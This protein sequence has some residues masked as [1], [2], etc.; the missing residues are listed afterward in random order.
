MVTVNYLVQIEPKNGFETEKV[1]KDGYRQCGYLPQPL[2]SSR[3]TQRETPK[4]KIQNMFILKREHVVLGTL[5]VGIHVKRHADNCSNSENTTRDVGGWGR[6]PHCRYPFLTFS[7][8]N[9]FLVRFVHNKLPL[10]HAHYMVL[11]DM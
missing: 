9:P 5:G 10:P 2:T 8:S 3:N 11:N 1:I 4:Q 6:Y 7:V